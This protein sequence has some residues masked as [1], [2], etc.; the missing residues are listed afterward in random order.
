MR[1]IMQKKT[2]RAIAFLTVAFLVACGDDNASNGKNDTN[3]SGDESYASIDDLP[4][5]T[6]KREGV[7]AFV[8]EDDATYICNDDDW[9]K[10]GTIYESVDDFP[11]CTEKRKDESVLEQKTGKAYT[12]NGKSWEEDGVVAKPVESSSSEKKTSSSS[13]SKKDSSDLK[14]SS[15][16]NLESSSSSVK[17]CSSVAPGEDSSDSK[18]SSSETP[19]SSSSSVK[20]SSSIAPGEDSS[21]S[22]SSSSCSSSEQEES[23]SSKIETGSVKDSRDGQVYKTVKIGNQ[24]WFAQNLNYDDSKLKSV[25]PMNVKANC[26]KYGRLYYKH[27]LVDLTTACPTGWRVPNYTEWKKLTEYVSMNNGGE[28]LA[29]SLKAT[30]DWPPKGTKL[31]VGDSIRTAATDGTDRFGF[32]ALP[33]GSCWGDETD[34]Y[35]GDDTRFYITNYKALPKIAFD[36]DVVMWDENALYGAYVSIRCLQGNPPKDTAVVDSMPP[37]A[38]VGSYEVMIEDLSVNGKT[39]VEKKYAGN[40][41]P[42]GWKLITEQQLKDFF[43]LGELASYLKPATYY[44]GESAVSACSVSANT[45]KCGSAPASGKVRCVKDLP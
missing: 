20:S 21:D 27:N 36:K 40:I 18:S 35:M 31:I 8:E 44:V 37:V 30:T 22:K 15:S 32:A 41:C 17:S 28:P 19:K 6:A 29:V 39:D 24:V 9:V 43:I 26:K 2:I 14:S 13:I 7:S 34:C 12:C 5:C 3:S 25:C 1:R 10:V 45:F 23:S 38:V 16:E 42:E 11:N 33:A 4:N